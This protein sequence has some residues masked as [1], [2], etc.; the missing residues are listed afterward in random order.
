MSWRDWFVSKPKRLADVVPKPNLATIRKRV[1][2][3]VID[4]DKNAF[5]VKALQTE[6]YMV[7]Y[8]KEVQSLDKLE[9]GEFD[10]IVLDIGGVAQ[11][12]SEEDG[13]G[14]LKQIKRRNPAQ[15]V[16]ALSGQTFDI[17]KSAFFKQ[18]DD[19]LTKP[20]DVIRCRQVIDDLMVSKCS[21]IGQWE[22]VYE[23][24]RARGLDEGVLSQLESKL[25]EGL[26]SSS[27]VSFRQRLQELVTDK[28][29]VTTSLRIVSGIIE[30][31]NK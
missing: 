11:H 6:G 7:E 29:I 22:A 14:V 15:V 21:I 2:I 20:V 30:A 4:D 1:K 31:Y 8:W 24:L 17:G 5:P 27:D 16:V 13:L 12:L 28:E 3:I 25:T 19:V 9:N 18:A 10:I 26:T 23:M